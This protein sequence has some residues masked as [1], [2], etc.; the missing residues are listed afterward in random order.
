VTKQVT[1]INP[2]TGKKE[3]V[4][5]VVDAPIESKSR[6]APV[7]AT[8]KVETK[9]AAKKTTSKTSTKKQVKKGSKGPE[10]EVEVIEEIIEIPAGQKVQ[11]KS[12]N[13]PAAG[14]RKV[15]TKG[16]NGEEE[17]VEIIEE[18]IELRSKG[19]DDED[20]V[21]VVEEVI[22]IPY[23]KPDQQRLVSKKVTKQVTRI[24]PVT[25]KKETVEEVVEDSTSGEASMIDDADEVEVMEEVIEVPY[26]KPEQQKLISKKVTKQISKINPK[27]GKKEIVE[28]VVSEPSITREAPVISPKKVETKSKEAPKVTQ[29][30]KEKEAPAKKAVKKTSSSKITVS[31]SKK[32]VTGPTAKGSS[33]TKL[34]ISKKVLRKSPSGKILGVQTLPEDNSV[35]NTKVTRTIVV[36]NKDGDVVE[37]KTIEGSIDDIENQTNSLIGTGAVNMTDGSSHVS[38]NIRRTVIRKNADGEILST[39]VKNIN[40]EESLD[41]MKPIS[42]L[43]FNKNKS[44]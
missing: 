16:P 13:A 26:D 30:K 19:G 5:E 11:T 22:E 42:L 35:S 25:G 29:K 41:N 32:V 17:E 44:S 6:E 33:T 38:T 37:T 3:T 34:T 31:S 40:D 23:D 7:T 36:K 28:E 1:R 20:E 15:V 39:E 9:P 18:V 24:N 10:E 4:E 21:E 8:K 27:T 14:S 12:R 43:S 2:V